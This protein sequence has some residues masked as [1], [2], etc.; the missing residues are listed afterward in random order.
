[1]CIVF[2]ANLSSIH[3]HTGTYNSLAI[4]NS[5]VLQNM[6]TCR[7]DENQISHS[8]FLALTQFTEEIQINKDI[9]L[10]RDNNNSSV[11]LMVQNQEQEI[12]PPY[13]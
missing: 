10:P 7:S 9:F 8:T 6:T 5:S 3:I 12:L 2:A 13:T 1:M 11:S 4:Y